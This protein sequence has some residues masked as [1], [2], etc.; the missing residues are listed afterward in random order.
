L[1]PLLTYKDFCIDAVDPEPLGRFWA[2]A[3][4][5]SFA[6][7]DDGEVKL[8]GT[9]PQRTVWINKVPETKSIKHRVHLDVHGA[10]PTFVDLGA[11]V[12]DESS[13]AWAVLADPEGGE[14]CVFRGDDAAR[15]R[16]VDLVFD[17]RDGAAMADWWGAAF[18]VDPAVSDDG[19]PVLIGVPDAPFAAIGFVEVPEPKTLKNRI[20]IDVRV[21]D[22][23]ALRDQGAHLLRPADGEIRWNVM[24]DPEGNEFCA[25]TS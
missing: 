13:F 14:F 20:H 16:A 1:K 11:R 2:D 8:F 9:T 6:L 22:L 17:C 10:V 4:G 5:L 18:D 21:T 24:A 15:P 23:D 19:T 25:F 3:L 12:V 7:L